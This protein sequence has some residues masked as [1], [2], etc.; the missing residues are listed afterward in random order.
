MTQS[1][2]VGNE[3]VDRTLHLLEGMRCPCCGS[4]RLHFDGN[5]VNP[6][7]CVQCGSALE[8]PSLLLGAQSEVKPLRAA[9]ER[10]TATKVSTQY[11]E[12]LATEPRA[13]GLSPSTV[14]L[15]LPTQL[16]MLAMML[17]ALLAFVLAAHSLYVWLN[18]VE[19]ILP[20]GKEGTD[21]FL[22]LD[23]P[24]GL[25]GLV[26]SCSAAG[27]RTWNTPALLTLD[28]CLLL[29]VVWYWSRRRGIGSRRV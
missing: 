8:V 19:G 6:W 21:L 7:Q 18:A 20:V 12:T 28:G 23:M 1:R 17:G 14:L 15:R 2:Q 9:W 25:S 16:L 29:C 13:A 26:D 24:W 22:V 3:S 4:S 5:Q 27:L 10:S 11:I